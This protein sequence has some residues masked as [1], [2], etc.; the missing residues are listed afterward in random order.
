MGCCGSKEDHDQDDLSEPILRNP[1]TRRNSQP[2]CPSYDT[3]DVKMEQD[4][5][6]DVIERTTSA[7]ADPLQGQDIQ[8]RADKYRWLVDRIAVGITTPCQVMDQDSPVDVLAEAEPNEGMSLEDLDELYQT[9]DCIQDAL[10]RIQVSP[11][12]DIVVTLTLNES[13]AMRGY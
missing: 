12:G 3:F 5:W 6:K 9:M 4:F 2:T 1:H 7:Q 10:H 8:E 11:V 13:S